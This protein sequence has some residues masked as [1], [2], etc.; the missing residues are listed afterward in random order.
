MRCDDCQR[1]I[2]I[3]GVGG[4]SVCV[5]VRRSNGEIQYRRRVTRTPPHII[6]SLLLLVQLL[7]AA[8]AGVSKMWIFCHIHNN[9]FYILCSI[10]NR[11]NWKFKTS[12]TTATMTVGPRRILLSTR[13]SFNTHQTQYVLI[14]THTHTRSLLSLAHLHTNDDDSPIPSNSC[15]LVV[16]ILRGRYLGFFFTNVGYHY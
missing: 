15:R 13:Q 10:R 7:L 12:Y 9:M 5:T 3:N 8:L 6:F 11:Q 14:R 16:I 1:V 2:E 4:R